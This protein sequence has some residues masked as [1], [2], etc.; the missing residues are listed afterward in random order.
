MI[1]G[2]PQREEREKVSE[3][4]DREERNMRYSLITG[5]E[6]KMSKDA[7]QKLRQTG[8]QSRGNEQRSERNNT[9]RE[10]RNISEH[11]N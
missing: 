5:I 9:M 6:T 3:R 2:Q 1:D 11:F 8:T 10:K 4:K 7:K